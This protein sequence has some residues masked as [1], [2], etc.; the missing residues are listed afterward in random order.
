M[1]RFHCNGIALAALL[2]LVTGCA[3]QST[4]PSS[5]SGYAIATRWK[6]GG[7]GGWDALTFDGSRHRLFITRGD[8]VDVLD[9][10]TGSILGTVAGLKGAH[11]VALA[12]ELQRGYATSGR[13]NAVV[14]FDYDNLGGGHEVAVPGG[15]NPDAILYEPRFR[16][17]FV[18]NGGSRNAVVFDAA[19]MKPLATLPMPGKPEF[20]V[21]DGHGRVFVNI[22]S[23]TGQIV[24]IDSAKIALIATW[25]LP[26][27]EEPSGLAFDRHRQRLFSACSNRVLAVTDAVSG[28]AGARLPIGE[29]PDGAAYDDARRRVLTSNGDGT[30]SVVP[31]FSADRYGS[32]LTLRTQRGARTMALDGSNG[33]VYLVTADYAPAPAAVEGQARM[34]P[35]YVPGSFVVLIVAPER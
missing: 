28:R 7:S 30:L 2:V 13:V 8:R 12:P 27:C 14:E 3:G 29:H 6:L 9:T 22:E 18:F 5:E 1:T 11:E 20:A 21:H 16:H 24:A 4:A 10:R 17:L 33:W 25:S 19:T 23:E 15:A 35:E 34:R 31:Q 26:G 32:T